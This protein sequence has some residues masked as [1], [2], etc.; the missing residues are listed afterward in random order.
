VYASH[1]Y[2]AH[3]STSWDRWFGEVAARYPVIMTEWGYLDPSTVEGP[4][5]LAGSR[6]TY[7]DRFLAYLDSREIGWVAC[8]YD[9]DWLPAMFE[10]D[11]KT[12]NA[13][14]EWVVESFKK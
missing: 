14:G 13:Y 2:P 4:D 12:L 5:Y 7:G 1:I 10:K 11:G 9:G 8:W 6:E 3:S